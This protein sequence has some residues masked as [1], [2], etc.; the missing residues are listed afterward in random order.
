MLENDF[1]DDENLDARERLIKI[2]ND[3]WEFLK[4]VRTKDQ[5]DLLKPIKPFPVQYDYL[6]LYVRIWQRERLLAVPKSRRMRLSWTTIALYTHDA[7]FNIGRH[8]AFVSKKDENSDELVQRAHF[9]CEN[10]D[11]EKLPK[12][13]LPKWKYTYNNLDFPEIDSKIQ[14]FPSGSDQLRQFTLSGMFFDEFAFWPEAEQAYSSAYPT[15]EGGGRCTMVSSP[16]PSFFQ[17]VVFDQIDRNH[18][19]QGGKSE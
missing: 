5:V 8:D 9:I 12:E 14:G 4:C 13:L 3:P 16:A 18:G 19:N 2:K 11:Y 7:L 17:R 1:S 15:L 10:L 6:K